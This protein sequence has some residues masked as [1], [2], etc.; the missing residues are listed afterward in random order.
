VPRA[1]GR[2]APRSS[3]GAARDAEAPERR[4][5]GDAVATVSP[6]LR[7]KLRTRRAA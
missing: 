7:W 1:A 6:W 2:S 4:R 3:L 5:A